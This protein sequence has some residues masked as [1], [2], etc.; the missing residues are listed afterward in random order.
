MT[1]LVPNADEAERQRLPGGGAR[2]GA[3]A[4]SPSTCI[5]SASRPG[6][7]RRPSNRRCRSRRRPVATGNDPRRLIADGEQREGPR[8][9]TALLA[10]LVAAAALALGLAAC[11][12]GGGGIEGG[13][14]EKEAPKVKLEGKPSRQPDDLQLAALHRQGHRARLRKSERRQ[15]SSTSKTSTP[16]KNSSTRCSRCCEQGESGG[17]SIFVLADY[18]VTKMH[19]LGYLQEFDKSGAAGSRKEPRR[20]PPAPAVRPQPRLHGAVAE[21]DDRGHRQ[22]GNGAG[23]AARSATSSTP[24]T[25]AKSTS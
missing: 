2:V 13:G 4:G 19:K 5:L 7:R 20:Q 24:S 22:Q 9:I 23:R 11:G 10:V 6:E 17:R 8:R 25:R 21:R 18:M 3:R 1:V 14:E 15:R 12:G 16:T